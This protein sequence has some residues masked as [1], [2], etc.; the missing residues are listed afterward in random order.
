MAARGWEEF[1]NPTN[2]KDSRSFGWD[3][4]ASGARQELPHPL[5]S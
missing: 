2:S 5:W 4:L 3:A 1:L